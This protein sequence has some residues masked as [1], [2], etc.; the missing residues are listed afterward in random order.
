[1]NKN[2]RAV[3]HGFTLIE[4]MVVVVI[5]AILAA[6]VVPRVMGRPAQARLVKARTD[7]LA[8][9][10][11]LEMYKLDNGI[12]PSTEQ[13]IRALVEQPTTAPL[14]S[15]WQGYLKSIPQDPWG[16]PYHYVCP[17]VHSA[18]DIYTLGPSPEAN[19]PFVANWQKH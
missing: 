15:D 14:P 11:A 17:G 16:R 8:I 2:R 7:I 12:Y 13:G 4:V 18:V 10:N 9:E 6:V 1:M 19:Q 5:L 3:A